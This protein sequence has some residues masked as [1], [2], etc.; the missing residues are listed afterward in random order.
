MK[1]HPKYLRML[2]NADP[3]RKRLWQGIECGIL[4]DGLYSEINREALDRAIGELPATEPGKDIWLQVDQNIQHVIR[5]KKTKNLIGFPLK[6]AATVI[7]LI[8]TFIVV[9]MVILNYPK[10]RQHYSIEEP[11]ETFLSKICSIY[12]KKC[13]EADFM[14]MKSEIIRLNDEK[15]EVENSIFFNPADTSIAKINDRINGQITILKSQ[16]MDYVE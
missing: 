16:I 15:S 14:E 12:P 6:I 1:R 4:I 8:S 9:K 3:D 2:K 10:N 5:I 13:S 11:V 7:L